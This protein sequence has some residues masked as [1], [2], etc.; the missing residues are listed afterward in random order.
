[1]A[2]DSDFKA[3]TF[4][5]VDAQNV[6]NNTFPHSDLPLER[7]GKSEGFAAAMD[8]GGNLM[9]ADEYDDE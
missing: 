7:G 6:F 1:M 3:E 8:M 2:T 9:S 5:G 4:K